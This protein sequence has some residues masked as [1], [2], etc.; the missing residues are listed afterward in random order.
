MVTKPILKWQY[1]TLCK[2]LLLLQGHAADPSCP[3]QSEGETCI[4]KHLMT[5]EALAQETTPM[6]TE[7]EKIQFLN[8][9]I[10]EARNVRAEEERHLCGLNPAPNDDLAE[11]AREKRKTIE[12]WSLACDLIADKEG[13]VVVDHEEGEEPEEDE[14]VVEEERIE[15]EAEEAYRNPQP[16]ETSVQHLERARSQIQ[17]EI[18]EAIGHLGTHIGD[19]KA[20]ELVAS[21]LNDIRKYILSGEH[22]DVVFTMDLAGNPVA[23]ATDEAAIPGFGEKLESCVLKVKPGQSKYNPYAVCRSSLRHAHGLNVASEE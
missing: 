23:L 18:F 19:A 20:G 6:E 5:V 15:H 10:V 22:G 1:E 4:R 12:G 21:W 11:W 17:D 16:G 3:C 8:L 7:L 9:M 2:E 13:L 14:E